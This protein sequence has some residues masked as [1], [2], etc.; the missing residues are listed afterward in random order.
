[1]NKREFLESL[2][3]VPIV[4]AIVSKEKEQKAQGQA[5]KVTMGGREYYLPVIDEPPSPDPKGYH[6]DDCD[7][8]CR[9]CKMR[10]AYRL[11]HANDPWRGMRGGD[12]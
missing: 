8:D 5:L 1:M 2:V 10:D 11:A 12:Q 9:L 4:A 6:E 3:A 7:G